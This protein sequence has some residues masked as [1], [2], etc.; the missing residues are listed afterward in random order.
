VTFGTDQFQWHAD[1]SSSHAD[2]DG[3]PLESTLQA[4]KETAFTLPKASLTI[5]RG[6]IEA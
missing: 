5:L 6:K 1:G 2:P 4:D 3:P